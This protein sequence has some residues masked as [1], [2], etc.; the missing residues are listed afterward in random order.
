MNM[1]TY[2]SRAAWSPAGGS[3]HDENE[4]IHECRAFTPAELRGMIAGNEI[5]DANTLSTFARMC[6]LGFI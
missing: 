1:A 2:S 6:A 4:V 5:L 3:R